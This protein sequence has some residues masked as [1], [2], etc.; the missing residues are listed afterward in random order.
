M[1]GNLL[2]DEDDDVLTPS[3]SQFV[4]RAIRRPSSCVHLLG[5]TDDFDLHENSTEWCPWHKND[6]QN[7]L[8]LE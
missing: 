6:V 4:P 7:I 8:K 3:T 1:I 5:Q 2:S